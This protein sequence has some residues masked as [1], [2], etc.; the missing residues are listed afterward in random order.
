MLQVRPYARTVHPLAKV[1]AII[2]IALIAVIGTPAV[3]EAQAYPG[4]T[5]EQRT[6]GDAGDAGD[7]LGTTAERGA[8]VRGVQVSRTQVTRG[9]AVTGGDILGLALLG[10][11]LVAGGAILVRRS[12]RPA[13]I[14][15]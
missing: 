14:L 4:G 5:T 12:R 9:L 11:G 1:V 6:T 2:T 15:A 3:V 10:G 8:E 13:A 7:V